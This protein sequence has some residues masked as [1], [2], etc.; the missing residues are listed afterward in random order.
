[1]KRLL[2]GYAVLSGMFAVVT[3]IAQTG[4]VVKY[5]ATIRDVKYLYRVTPPVAR[6]VP[7]KLRRRSSSMRFSSAYCLS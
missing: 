1:M 6:L 7:S 5:A 2:V 3:A 4:N